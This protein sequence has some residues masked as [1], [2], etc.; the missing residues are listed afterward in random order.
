MRGR[1]IRI[2]LILVVLLGGLFVA[3]DRLAVSYA[4]SKAAEKIQRSQGLADKPD[5]SIKG[6]P[7]LTQVASKKLDEVSVTFTGLQTTSDSGT[8]RVARLTADGHGVQLNGDLMSGNIS[9]AV[10]DNATGTA[11]ISYADLSKSASNGITVAYGGKGANG[12]GQLKVTGSVQLP[13]VGTQQVSVMSHVEIKNGDAVQL[14][15]DGMPSI[16]GISLPVSAEQ[17]VRQQTDFGGQLSG[18]PSGIKLTSA[19]ATPDGLQV[20]LSGTNVKLG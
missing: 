13:L 9:S 18:L 16:M 1:G 3:A 15:A 20:S 2:L 6:F 19:E 10:A 11:L 8:L 5:V 14:H 17:L 12:K 7:F 4:E